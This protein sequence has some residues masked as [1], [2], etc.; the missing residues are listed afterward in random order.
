MKNDGEPEKGKRK[1]RERKKVD[2]KCEGKQ[3]RWQK[4]IHKY[5]KNGDKKVQKKVKTRNCEHRAHIFSNIPS[6][7]HRWCVK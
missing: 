7:L 2:K 4:C 3:R 5:R 1:K 6:Y